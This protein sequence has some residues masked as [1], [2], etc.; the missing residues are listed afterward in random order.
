MLANNVCLIYVFIL[1]KHKLHRTQA[2]KKQNKKVLFT[3]DF[4]NY[5]IV[6]QSE[7]T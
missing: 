1:D 6:D 3:T 5:K 4:T 2:N 7:N